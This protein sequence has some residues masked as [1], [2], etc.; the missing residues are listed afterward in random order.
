MSRRCTHALK[1]H[2]NR[3]DGYRNDTNIAD[4]LPHREKGACDYVWHLF[5]KLRRPAADSQITSGQTSTG[6]LCGWGPCVRCRPIARNLTDLTSGSQLPPITALIGSYSNA[7][8]SPVNR[9]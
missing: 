9:L 7:D 6:S 8:Q 4:L 3:F 1:E 2:G 5:D